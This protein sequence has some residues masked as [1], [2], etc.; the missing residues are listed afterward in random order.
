[1]ARLILFAFV[2]CNDDKKTPAESKPAT[3]VDVVVDDVEDQK[4]EE[5]PKPEA[6][7]EPTPQRIGV[8]SITLSKYSV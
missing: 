8:E 5:Q 7:Q 2:G 3:D 1:M 6:P 4:G